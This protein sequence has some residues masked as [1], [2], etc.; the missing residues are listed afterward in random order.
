[1]PLYNTNSFGSISTLTFHGVFKLSKLVRAV[2]GWTQMTPY[3]SQSDSD[4]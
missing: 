2:Q 4:T 3:Y 1:L